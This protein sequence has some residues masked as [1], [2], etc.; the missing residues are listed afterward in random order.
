MENLL[1]FTGFVLIFT[2][3]TTNQEVTRQF[4]LKNELEHLGGGIYINEHK[5]KIQLYNKNKKQPV[6]NRIV[7]FL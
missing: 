1:I 3:C 7:Y 5:T 2:E 6:G 4:P